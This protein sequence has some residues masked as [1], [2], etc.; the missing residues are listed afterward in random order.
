M[1]SKERIKKIQDYLGQQILIENVSSYVSYTDS[2]ITEWEFLSTI[3]NQADCHILLDINNIY[4]SAFNH[5]FDPL[6]YLKGIPANRVYQI[7][8]AGHSNYVSY[9]LDTHDAPVIADVWDLY[10]Q[11]IQIIGLVST[12]IERDDNIPLFAELLNELEY[13]RQVANG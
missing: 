8:L 7:H 9:L 5:K 12:M 2:E 13:A 1:D 11:S 4:V 3:A 6:T 10:R